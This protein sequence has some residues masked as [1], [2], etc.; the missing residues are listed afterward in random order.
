MDMSNIE[1]LTKDFADARAVV[2]DR[3]GELQQLTQELQRRHM[4]GIRSAVAKATT[5]HDALAAAV[6]EA[7]DLFEKPRTRTMH[8]IRVGITKQRGE[9]V[10]SDEPTTIALIRKH[11]PDQA[12]TLI[13]TKESVAKSQ[14]GDLPAKDLKRIGVEITADTDS[15][16]IKAAD[17]ELDKLLQALLNDDELAET[18]QS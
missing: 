13:R 18:L 17:N 1:A 6:A 4:R 15:V 14:L 3:L 2:Q 7:P 5:A 10:V 8:G 9:V 12:E 16:T 11:L